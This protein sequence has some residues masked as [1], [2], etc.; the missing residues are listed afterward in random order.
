MISRIM[1]AAVVILAAIASW[2]AFNGQLKTTSPVESGSAAPYEQ[3]IHF[4]EIAAADAF[5]TPSSGVLTEFFWYGCPHCRDFEPLLATWQKGK[6]A[7]ESVTVEQIPVV[8]NETSEFHAR[9][10]FVADSVPDAH[11]LHSELFE[12]II[13]MRG[14]KDLAKQESQ[15]AP[16]FASYGLPAEMLSERLRSDA[17]SAA[18]TA[19]AEKMRA[20]QI[21]STP[22]VLVNHK[23]LVLTDDISGPA[24]VF[25]IADFLLKDN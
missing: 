24:E 12:Q 5:E 25:D 23:W 2:V 7:D 8:W 14:E 6:D 16:L 22:S 11:R 18:V 15:L 1:L 10:Y 4:R 3:G 13:A 19:S 9:L 20:A 21:S 17:V